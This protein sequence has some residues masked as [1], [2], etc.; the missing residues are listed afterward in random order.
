MSST[1]NLVLS[2]VFFTIASGSTTARLCIRYRKQR[3]WWDDGWAIL[4][5]ILSTLVDIALFE[6][7]FEAGSDPVSPKAAQFWLNVT[8]FTVGVWS[9]RIS[10]ILSVVRLIP[11][12]FTLRRISE[13][14]AVLFFLMCVGILIPKIYFCASSLSWDGPVPVCRL[15]KVAIGELITDVLADITLV[16]IPIRLLGYVSLPKDKRR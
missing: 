6:A 11:P 7:V 8:S 12:L 5:L 16:A 2:V 14:A 9:A 13:W 10:L 4:T 15:E 3:L 1:T